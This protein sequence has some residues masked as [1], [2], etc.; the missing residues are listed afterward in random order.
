MRGIKS[1]IHSE[2]IYTAAV[3]GKKNIFIGFWRPDVGHREED[4]M[5]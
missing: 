5:P 2:S 3:H 4:M 1:L